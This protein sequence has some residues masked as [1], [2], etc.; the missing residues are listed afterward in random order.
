MD[1]VV[2]AR[3]LGTY[4]MPWNSS[5]A[6]LK[7]R[8]QGGFPAPRQ[9]TKSYLVWMSRLGWLAAQRDAKE[10]QPAFLCPLTLPTGRFTSAPSFAPQIRA[11]VLDGCLGNVLLTLCISSGLPGFS[12]SNFVPLPELTFD[13]GLLQAALMYQ[14]EP[15]PTLCT[16]MSL[17]IPTLAPTKYLDTYLGRYPAHHMPNIPSRQPAPSFTASIPGVMQRLLSAGTAPAR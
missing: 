4:R 3:S 2:Q 6:S 15:T 7:L 8:F 12:K 10:G 9:G 14:S 1:R 5:P 16:C 13:D 17:K 11:G